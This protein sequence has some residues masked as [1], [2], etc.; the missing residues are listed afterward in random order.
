MFN[1]ASL[2]FTERILE[3]HRIRFDPVDLSESANEARSPQTNAIE[4]EI[5][6]LKVGFG[7]RE[8][9]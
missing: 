3:K 4:R 5:M 7:G 6:G 9:S 8:I 2:R 1:D